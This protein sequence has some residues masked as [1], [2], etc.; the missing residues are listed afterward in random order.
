[1]DGET[2]HMNESLRMTTKDKVAKLKQDLL[3]RKAMLR[4][5]IADDTPESDA[6]D[7]NESVQ[8]DTTIQEQK[9][10]EEG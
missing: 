8:I 10:I 9:E 7:P 1:M 4:G 5:D 2:S 3:K 6:V